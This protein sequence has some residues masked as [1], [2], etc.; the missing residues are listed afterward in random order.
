MSYSTD[1]AERLAETLERF[2]SLNVYQLVGH[3]P[4]LEFWLTEAEGVMGILDGYGARFR[5]MHRA[6]EGWV[7]A[8]H[9]RVTPFCPICDG[10]CEFGPRRPPPPRRVPNAQID[11]AR[12]TLREALRR[13]LLRLYRLHMLDRGAAIEA[14]D[15]IGTGFEPDELEREEPPQDDA[16]APAGLDSEQVNP[17]RR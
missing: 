15:R 3:V 12:H 11:D 13:F 14:A 7:K 10:G 9:V 5:E 8:H 17:R 1:R 4:N 2:T 6:Q 16:S